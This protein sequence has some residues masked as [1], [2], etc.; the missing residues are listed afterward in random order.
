MTWVF[1]LAKLIF[2]LIVLWLIVTACIVAVIVIKAAIEVFISRRKKRK[3]KH[4]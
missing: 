1:A 3:N 4:V 2:I